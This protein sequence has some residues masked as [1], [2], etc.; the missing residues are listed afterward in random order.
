ML[1]PG[2][3]SRQEGAGGSLPFSRDLCRCYQL[4]EGHGTALGSQVRAVYIYT[5]ILYSEL[6]L[7]NSELEILVFQKQTLTVKKVMDI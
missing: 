7:Y 3:V 5:Y 1:P 2:V 6:Y 4:Q